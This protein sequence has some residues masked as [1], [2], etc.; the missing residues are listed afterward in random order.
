M[1]TPSPS[2]TTAAAA[3]AAAAA[4]GAYIRGESNIDPRLAADVLGRVCG[5]GGGGGIEG[6][7]TRLDIDNNDV[8]DDAAVTVNAA[9]AAIEENDVGDVINGGVLAE[10]AL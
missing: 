7:F 2:P 3:A 5:G 8:D 10:D 9:A 1:P 6:K 4:S